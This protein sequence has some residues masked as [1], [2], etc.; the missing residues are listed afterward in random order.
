MIKTIIKR[1]VKEDV[2]TN[3]GRA[4]VIRLS[5]ILGIL[6]NTMIFSF[7]LGLGLW[8][9]SIAIISDAFN[10]LSDIGSSLVSIITAKLSN[11]PPDEEHPH[12]HG[13]YEYIGSL[14][15]AYIIGTVG[16]ELLQQSYSKILNPTPVIF[17]IWVFVILG[18]NLLIKTSSMQPSILNSRFIQNN[19]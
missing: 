6:C 9:N 3:D 10:N 2:Y 15:V 7:K 17:S 11:L 16:F 5:G 1:F 12:G 4:E 18:I 14:V 8:V 13:R 19:T